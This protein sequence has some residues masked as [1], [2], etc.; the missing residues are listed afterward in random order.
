MGRPAS[1]GQLGDTSAAAVTATPSQRQN[2]K[3]AARLPKSTGEGARGGAEGS[4]P[5][6]VPHGFLG[7]R[8]QPCR[9][10]VHHEPRPA[11]REEGGKWTE[12]LGTEE[13]SKEKWCA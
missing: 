13:H 2:L 8:V 7:L 6:R 4:A 11:Q 5:S 1:P 10:G 12:S 3:I 9:D